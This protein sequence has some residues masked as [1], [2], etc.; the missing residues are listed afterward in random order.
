[1]PTETEWR[2]RIALYQSQQATMDRAKERYDKRQRMLNDVAAR[3][4]YR[5]QQWGNLGKTY[6]TSRPATDPVQKIEEPTELA[7]LLR[8]TFSE[9]RAAEIDEGMDQEYA[10]Y[11][12]EQVVTEF[13]V[14][15]SNIAQA[16]FEQYKQL[17]PEASDADAYSQ[18]HRTL[19][20]YGFQPRGLEK[21]IPFAVREGRVSQ[22]DYTPVWSEARSLIL[23]TIR[24]ARRLA[25][26]PAELLNAGL[27]MTSDIFN[28]NQA[29]AQVTGS[30][31][32]RDARRNFAIQMGA[33]DQ[34]LSPDD[35]PYNFDVAGIMGEQIPNLL[36]TMSGAGLIS[37]G[38]KLAGNA[39]ALGSMFAAEGTDAY[40][41]YMQ[42]GEQQGLDPRLITTQA[43]AGAIA[44]GAASAALERL[45]PVETFKRIPGFKNRVAA[46][47]MGALAESSTEFL[48]SL[49]QAGIGDVVD[50]GQF[51]WNSIRQAVREAAAGA[52]VGGVAGA[53]TIGRATPQ[54]DRLEET[55]GLDEIK[56]QIVTELDT[57]K[58]RNT[59]ANE[60]DV[61]SEWQM[62]PTP[63]PEDTVQNATEA[64]DRAVVET[65]NTRSKLQKLR[66]AWRSLVGTPSRLLERIPDQNPIGRLRDT[67]GHGLSDTYKVPANWIKGKRA[68]KG[69][70]R[71]TAH[72]A[73]LMGALWT[74]ELAAAG[75]DPES[76]ELH[77]VAQMVLE[78]R[79]KLEI[80]PPAMRAWVETART[81]QDAESM[82]AARIYRAAGLDELAAKFEKNIG[83]YL[84]RIPLVE[85]QTLGKARQV[86]RKALKLKT[87]AAFGKRRRDKWRVRDGKK[88]VGEFETE[89]EAREAY[90][91]TIAERKRGVIKKRS[92]AKGVSVEDI[93]RQAAKNVTIEEPIPQEW[94]DQFG[95]HDPR[96][97][98]ALSMVEARHDAEMV[99]LFHKTALR[100]G[101]EAPEGLSGKNL[102]GWAK[103]NGLVQLP[104][105]ARLHNLS[106]V[107]VPE[108]IASDLNEMTQLPSTA[109][110]AYQAY[111]GAWKSS[112]TLWN[113][114]T[115]ARN[116]YGNVLVFSYLARVSAL[117]PLNAKFYRQAATSLL[118]KDD[119]YLA[120][121][122]NGALGGEY[123]GGEIQRIEKALKSGDDTAIGQILAG[124]G[125]VQAKLGETYAAEDQIFKLAAYHK[126]KT[127]GMA[128]EEAAEEVNK[129]FPNYERTGKVTR[130]LRNSPVGAPFISF[131]DQSV[132]IAGR[133]IAERPLRV[134]AIAAMPGII[135]YISA[136]A[137]GLNPD[138]KEL[139]DK[140]RSYF[141]PLMPWRDDRGRVQAM[142]LRYI[143][144]LAND[145]IPEDR[146]GSLM[147][148]WMFSGPAATAAI[149]QFS[150]KER[151]TGKEFIREDM[152]TM[153]K[154]RA[155][156]ATVVRAAVPHPSF[157]YW[158]T[159]RI[160]GSITGDRDEHVANA[161]I[162]SLM[163]LNVRTPYIAEKHVKQVIQNMIADEDWREAKVLLDVWNGRY[164]PG[165]LKN[166]TIEGMARGLRQKGL[167]KWRKVRDN[168]A[169]ALLQGRD[170]DAKEIVDDYMA[171]LDPKDR[172]LFLPAVEYRARE[173]RIQG[174]TR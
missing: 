151:F 130:W 163:G 69:R 33:V 65:T 44:Y 114:A 21:L 173:L 62:I 131:V 111:L 13:L 123:Y 37:R 26:A 106:G 42:Y 45:I 110:R 120:L 67:I 128:T 174:R 49:T 76:G 10:G 125:V 137:I 38:S 61:V 132:R 82:Y 170:D 31:I 160:I 5:V 29:G 155:R 149:E 129:W 22:A 112:K 167:A 117:N 17:R 50:L 9:E 115:H 133:G 4:D 30:N 95:V 55:L 108:A 91:Q 83:S 97:L 135:N 74:K 124:I 60:V 54:V 32:F 52:I 147:I 141:E 98:L 3:D 63:Q 89:S 92:A 126:Y 113:P 40:N 27:E 46:W 81:M 109:K 104:Q 18:M 144:P 78:G 80:L 152:T 103:K 159:K 86:V 75:L 96:F 161:I 158:G 8:G 116:I 11:V 88:L 150:G 35:I 127:E 77:A 118:T 99:Q 143:L 70:E 47:S 14:R 107:F 168:A 66:K 145:I 6:K 15:R 51:D 48:Q 154:A 121:L 138:E 64:I 146:R 119:A 12:Q 93:N 71:L 68:A 53:A 140:E 156:L 39:L 134:A 57:L 136:I 2:E 105:I 148:P 164:K 73:D 58:S 85:V 25:T 169:S 79:A 19:I 24:G 94:W 72:R 84:K 153:E 101:Q 34:I 90:S 100:W 41:N 172:K 20:Q 102:D 122:E 1:M 139:L 142:D 59:I 171:E 157:T 36:A 162:G 56:A 165:H 16:A 28:R 43:Y 166:L 87:S 7:T 23:G